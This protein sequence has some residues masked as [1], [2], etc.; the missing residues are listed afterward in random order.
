MESAWE[1]SS[2]RLGRVS[3]SWP[4]AILLMVF[5]ARLDIIA[6]EDHSD[7]Q[8]PEIPGSQ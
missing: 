8:P 5:A 7:S 3:P 1:C 6:G 2:H 4:L